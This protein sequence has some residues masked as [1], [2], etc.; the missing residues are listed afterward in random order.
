MAV[1]AREVEIDGLGAQGDGLVEL[2]EGLLYIP[3][4]LPGE[5]W[6]VADGERYS[7]LRPHPE[8]VDPVCPH[9]G[10]CGGC[11]AQH[12]PDAFY[13]GWKRRST[14]CSA[15]RSPAGVASRSMPGATAK[16]C[17]SASIAR[18]RTTS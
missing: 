15:C 6:R 4:A 3:Y 11:D 16:T 18:Q 1:K 12:M 10:S 9:F 14:S 13:A 8:R 17:T 2:P 5:L 7:L